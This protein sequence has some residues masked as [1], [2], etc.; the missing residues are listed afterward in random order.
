MALGIV[1]DD[2]DALH[3]Y[4]FED[5][6]NEILSRAQQLLQQKDY[7]TIMIHG[8]GTDVGK[9]HLSNT[10]SRELNQAGVT[11]MWVNDIDEF[12]DPAKWVPPPKCAIIFGASKFGGVVPNDRKAKYRETINETFKKE[13]EKK[14]LPLSSVDIK[15]AIHSPEKPFDIPAGCSLAAD[16]VILNQQSRKKPGSF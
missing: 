11:I 16:I 15:V 6:K 9:S 7:I 4:T 3:E 10:L 2:V 12:G 14:G 5:G 1:P 8:N 13:A